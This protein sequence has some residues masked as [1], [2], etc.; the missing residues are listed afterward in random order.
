VFWRALRWAKQHNLATVTKLSH[1]MIFDAP[2]CVVEDS[3][4]LLASGHATMTATLANFGSLTAIRSEAVMMVV[5]RW[6]NETVMSQYQPARYTVWNEGHTFRT[7]CQFVDA[8]RPFP[9]FLPWHRLQYIRGADR[10][11]T[12]FRAM[13]GNVLPLYRALAAKHGLCLSAHFSVVDSTGSADY[14]C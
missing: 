8:D 5:D 9:H 12:Y 6:S 2:N 7:I 10:P 13:S 11:P 14:V 4:L 1:R 3:A